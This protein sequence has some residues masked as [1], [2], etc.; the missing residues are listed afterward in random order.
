MSFIIMFACLQFMSPINIILNLDCF[1]LYVNEVILAVAFSGM[2]SNHGCICNSFVLIYAALH[3]PAYLSPGC[4]TNFCCKLCSP[5]QVSMPLLVVY[6]QHL[7]M[8]TNSIQVLKDLAQTHIMT[9]ITHPELSR[10]LS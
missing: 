1:N 9:L 2:L 10:F 5:E 8:F 7:L 6:T 3:S 4:I